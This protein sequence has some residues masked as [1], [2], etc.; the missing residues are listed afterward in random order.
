MF[1]T[2]LKKYRGFKGNK[3]R[4]SGEAWILQIYKSAVGD[5]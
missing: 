4:E 2:N 3:N 1:Y 5:T